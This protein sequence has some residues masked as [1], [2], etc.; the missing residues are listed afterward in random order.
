MG[1]PTSIRGW[2][3][4]GCCSTCTVTVK[5]QGCR[6]VSS[7]ESPVTVRMTKR[8]RSLVR[9]PI[10]R[11]A[12]KTSAPATGLWSPATVMV[13]SRTSCSST[14]WSRGEEPRNARAINPIMG[15]RDIWPQWVRGRLHG[16]ALEPKPTRHID[17][18]LEWIPKANT[19]WD[20]R[21]R[22]PTIVWAVAIRPNKRLLEATRPC[23]SR[24]RSMDVD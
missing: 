7:W 1:R 19:D 9:A 5:K 12:I 24:G 16:T 4:S 23:R 6:T 17:A 15:V 2:R 13:P 10:L 14:V 18:S 20:T 3:A 21:P 8:P 22:T 11:A